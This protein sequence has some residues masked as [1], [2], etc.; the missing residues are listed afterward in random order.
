MLNLAV[1]PA[2]TLQ[3][4]APA[5]INIFLHV[6]GRRD[7]GY[8]LLDSGVVFADIGDD[9]V[10][11]KSDV[12]SLSTKGPFAEALPNTQ[13]NLISKAVKVFDNVTGQKAKV[14]IE[15]TKNLPLAAGI[16]GGSADAACVLR[17]LCRLYDVAPGGEK[18]TK[19]LMSLGADLPV[20]F[21]GRSARVKAAGENFSEFDSH[22]AG[23]GIVL[24]N[25]MKSC[26]TASV[27]QAYGEPFSQETGHIDEQALGSTRNDLLPAACSIVPEIG[28]ILE[29]IR[30]QTTPQ[31]A[32]MS[33]SGATCYGFYDDTDSANRAAR[34]IAKHN[35]SW[36]VKAGR[37][38]E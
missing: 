22:L 17:G 20:C 3:L 6:T 13:D 25:A 26:P 2:H 28:R 19:A 32:G 9:I 29:V 23:R 1:M 7:D 5:K 37:I 21:A 15:L 30:T 36:W 35:S 8:H 4:K 10:L 33:G 38:L 18:W 34:K 27:F 14:A 24:V 31:H 12:Y 16:G 11:R